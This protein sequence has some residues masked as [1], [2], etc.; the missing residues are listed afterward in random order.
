ME[1]HDLQFLKKRTLL[2][3]DSIFLRLVVHKVIG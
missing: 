1:A 3:I 2:M